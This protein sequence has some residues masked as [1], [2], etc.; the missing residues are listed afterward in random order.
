M[1]NNCLWLPVE[2]GGR[3]G[4]IRQNIGVNTNKLPKINKVSIKNPINRECSHKWS[5]IM[6]S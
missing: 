4:T 6:S 3:Y 5:R 2:Q 1:T